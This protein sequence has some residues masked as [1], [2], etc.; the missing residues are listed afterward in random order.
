MSFRFCLLALFFS[1][2]LPMGLQAQS[3]RPVIVKV[4]PSS[5]VQ[6]AGGRVDRRHKLTIYGRNFWPEDEK[7][8]PRSKTLVS[9]QMRARSGYERVDNPSF[10]ISEDLQTLTITFSEMQFLR[11]NNT[12]DVVVNFAGRASLPYSIPV[13][14]APLKAPEITSIEPPTFSVL[15]DLAEGEDPAEYYHFRLKGRNFDALHNMRLHIRG[16]RT[17][18]EKG[19]IDDGWIEATVPRALWNIPGVHPVRVFTRRG[20]SIT[21]Y[22]TLEKKEEE[23]QVPQPAPQEPVP[24]EIPEEE[25]PVPPSRY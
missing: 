1:L 10:G 13:L 9:V 2:S 15:D 14:S 22:I 17:P 16:L 6:H 12:L 11:G 7:M 21:K 25:I 20:G 24:E 23:E 3:S 4:D 8:F 19:D 5:F 18:I